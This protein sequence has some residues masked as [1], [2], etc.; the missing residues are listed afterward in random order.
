MDVRLKTSREARRAVRARADGLPTWKPAA[1]GMGTKSN[2]A[3]LT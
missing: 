2:W 1:P 3:S